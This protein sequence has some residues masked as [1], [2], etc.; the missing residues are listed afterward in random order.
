M[1]ALVVQGNALN[2]PLEDES[3]DLIITSP[4]YFAL[5]SY[6]DDG[7]HYEG[8][9]GSE[10]TPQQ[11][12][13][14]LWAATKE[15]WRVLKP[16]G[17]VFV[18]LGDKRAG[19]G[20]HNNSGLGTGNLGKERMRSSTLSGG[21]RRMQAAHED[22][23][24]LRTVATRR[25]AP[26]RYNQ[27]AFGRTKSR[28]MLPE[29][30]A[31]GCMD[32]L[33]APEGKGWIVRQVIIWSKPNGLPESVTDRTR[34]NWESWFHLVKEPRYFSAVDEIREPQ[35]NGPE[36]RRKDLGGA[37]H[38]ERMSNGRHV[39]NRAEWEG[40][41]LGAL[42]GSVWSIPS[43]PLIVPEWAKQKYDLPDHFAAFPTE[44]P[45]RL[46]LGFSPN[47]V[48]VECGEGRRPVS[49]ITYAP[50]ASGT[51]AGRKNDAR[52]D[53]G[54]GFRA[55][56]T[57]MPKM[58]RSA[59]ITS[60]AC[61]CTPYTNQLHLRRIAPETR[62]AVIL[63]PF[64]GTGTVGLVAK[65]LGRHGISVDLSHDYCELARWRINES[66]HGAKALGRTWSE[67]QESLL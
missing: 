50:S 49:K 18:N 32:G 54:T 24:V 48:C 40:N 35:K 3:V 19:S 56:L 26:D 43:E 47:G 11:F 42:P 31:I 13:E 23:D 59:T 55:D 8:Q 41:P 36:R 25:N 33:A 1:S 62:P 12:L 51:V 37:G 10:E 15:M 4:P 67:R 46:I 28:M 63:D 44:W 27:A 20:G 45:R 9:I 29:R 61:R 2:L 22:G 58:D 60:F 14:A 65:A 52:R 34:D 30:F 6:R 38:H 17:S 16:T 66:G 7:E 5:R 57:G 39:Q 53:D 64:G 21:K